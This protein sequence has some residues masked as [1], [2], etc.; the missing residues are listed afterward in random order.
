MNDTLK[1]IHEGLC[2]THQ[3]PRSIVGKTFRQGFYWPTALRDAQDL[4]QRCQGCQWASRQPKAPSLPLQPLPPVW[5]F[6]RWGLDVNGPYPTARG[7]LRFAFVAI[8]YFSRWVEAEP[9]AKI[10]SAIAQRFIWRTIICRYGVPRDIVTD[11]GSQFDSLAFRAFCENLGITICFASVGHPEVNGTVERTN[12]NL[13]EGLKKRL[14]ELP[15]GVWPEELQK[16]L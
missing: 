16:A 11:N 15:K 6:A 8:E 7:S 9:V 13:L 3:E 5:P 2:G 1:E 14:V 12:G 4:V 10:T